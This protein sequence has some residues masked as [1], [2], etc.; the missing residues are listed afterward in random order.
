MEKCYTCVGVK[1]GKYLDNAS[2]AFP[3]RE[4]RFLPP[5]RFR[6]GQFWRIQRFSVG[7]NLVFALSP[8]PVLTSRWGEYKIRPTK[9]SAPEPSTGD[10]QDVDKGRFF[11]NA[12]CRGRFSHT[13]GGFTEEKNPSGQTLTISRSSQTCPYPT[14]VPHAASLCESTT[15][16]QLVRCWLCESLSSRKR[17]AGYNTPL[18]PFIKQVVFLKNLPL[19]GARMGMTE[20]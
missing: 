15:C 6:D 8:N 18:T 10:G 4:R 17:G 20:T 14:R 1:R 19:S 9:V 2:P 13:N 5:R 3:S 16:C 7:A 11:A 12:F